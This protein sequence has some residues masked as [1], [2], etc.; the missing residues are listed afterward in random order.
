VTG[1]TGPRGLQGPTGAA[2]TIEGPTGAQGAQGV[3]INVKGSVATVGNLPA[4]GNTLNDAY[5]ITATGDLWVWNGSIWSNVGRLVGPTGP[6]GIQGV[7]GITGPTGAPSTVTGPLGPTGPNGAPLQIIGTV[8]TVGDLP[9]SALPGNGVVVGGT[10]LYVWVATTSSWLNAGNIVGPTGPTGPGITGP[11]GA[12]STVTGPTGPTGPGI[13][14]P[15]GPAVTGPTGP[16]FF[17]LTGATYTTTR[18]LG[19]ADAGTLIRMNA[20]SA[21][22]V[23]V[24][25]D[26]TTN[27]PVG[28]QIV[29]VQL[30]IGQITFSAAGGVSI[31]TEGAKRTTKAQY[32]TA[33]LIK[34]SADSWLLSGNLTV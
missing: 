10:D 18:T 11:T 28:T 14:G 22:S 3:S 34:L 13:T 2:S 30:G 4:S 17:N 6:Q 23:V 7:Q 33:S 26:I 9:P 29:L 27:F 1:A 5:I 25:A 31:Y 16:A 15:T 32:A 20:A 24:P 19:L 12:Q 21:T 8:P